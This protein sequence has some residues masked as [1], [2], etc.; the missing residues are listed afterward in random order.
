MS[1]SD[2][3]KNFWSQPKNAKAATDSI[4]FICQTEPDDTKLGN[5]VRQ[6]CRPNVGGTSEVKTL[7]NNT[8]D[9][10]ELGRKFREMFAKKAE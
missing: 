7:V 9:D 2:F 3:I 6:M 8:P 10:T 5:L 4:G 1:A